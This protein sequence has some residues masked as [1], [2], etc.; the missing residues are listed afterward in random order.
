MFFSDNRFIKHI[1][2]SE[3]ED[4]VFIESLFKAILNSIPLVSQRCTYVMQEGCLGGARPRLYE[5]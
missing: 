5:M 2:G 1:E 4:M 3:D